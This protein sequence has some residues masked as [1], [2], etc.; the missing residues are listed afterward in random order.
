[1]QNHSCLINKSFFLDLIFV[2]FE[3]VWHVPFKKVWHV[4]DT[5]HTSPS[6][7]LGLPPSFWAHLAGIS[8][9]EINYLVSNILLLFCP[10]ISAA[11]RG[12]DWMDQQGNLDVASFS[13]IAIRID[14]GASGCSWAQ[15]AWFLKQKN[16]YITNYSM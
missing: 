6:L 12:Q 11:L 15:W 2:T 4:C 16:M 8:G 13:G 1:M 3:K 7:V 9:E 5:C 10:A 14:A